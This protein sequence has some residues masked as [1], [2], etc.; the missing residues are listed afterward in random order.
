MFLRLK[1]WYLGFL[2]KGSYTFIEALFCY[3]LYGLSFIYGLIVKVRNILY[4]FN[5]L[6]SY[7]SK[8]KIMS[9]GNLSWAGSGKTPLSIWFHKVFSSRYKVAILRRGYGQDE[10]KLIKEDTGDVFSTPNRVKI[11]QKVESFF[12]LFILD[13]GFQYRK[14]KKDINILIMGAREFRKKYRLIPAYF[15]REH[16]NSIKRADIVILNYVD[17][18][19]GL[20]EIEK[21]I[22]RVAPH[23]KI[24]H[25][26][27]KIKKFT[28]LHNNKVEESVIKSKRLAAFTAIGYPQGFF[29]KLEE[30]D[31]DIL[32]HIE[33]PD[34]YELSI[35]EFNQIQEDLIKENIQGLVI[36]AKDKYHIPVAEKKLDIY[37]L[38]IEMDIQKAD[39]LI[40]TIRDKLLLTR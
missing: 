12:D 27:Y 8:S 9:I 3:F 10:E 40:D 14:L 4:D 24:Y 32:R 19:S 34:H 39:D 30:A 6:P 35:D 1:L 20:P 29:R 13:D 15:F 31:L 7:R 16:F 22:L 23:V 5:F 38:E 11:I 28:D 36:T 37:I 25:S 26:R 17:D 33:Y 2:D 21:S 18:I